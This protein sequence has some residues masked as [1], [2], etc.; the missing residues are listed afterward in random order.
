MKTWKLITIVGAVFVAIALVT[1]SAA[2]YMGGNGTYVPQSTGNNG[3][4]YPNSSCGGM[5]GYGAYSQ[6]V[7]AYP[8]CGR[9][10]G[11]VIYPYQNPKNGAVRAG[12]CGCR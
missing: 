8:N 1:A 7:G 3:V 12:C 10:N 11:T 5:M 6:Y 2:A 4:P 9:C